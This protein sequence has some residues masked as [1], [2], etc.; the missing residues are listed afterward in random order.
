MQICKYATNL[1]NVACKA[2]LVTVNESLLAAKFLKHEA[3]CSIYRLTL[4]LTANF[5]LII[6]LTIDRSWDM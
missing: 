3:T 1:T 6:T 5:N 2:M 4:T